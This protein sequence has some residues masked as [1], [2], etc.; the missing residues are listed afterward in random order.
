VTEHVVGCTGKKRFISFR[1]ASRAAKRLRQR[2][3]EA[4]TEAYHCRH[5]AGF[6]VGEARDHGKRDQRK[7]IEA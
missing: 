4:H 1:T 5:C 3:D 2:D 7:D 6:H